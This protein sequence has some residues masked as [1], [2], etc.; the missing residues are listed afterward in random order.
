MPKAEVKCVICME[1]DVNTHFEDCGH[2]VCCWDC[3]RKLELKP[4]QMPY[5]EMRGEQVENWSKEP[6]CPCCRQVGPV[7]K[8]DF[9]KRRRIQGSKDCIDLN[10]MD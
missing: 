7:M 3:A 5:T 8:L 1:A 2:E 4:Y 6:V 9:M 10:V